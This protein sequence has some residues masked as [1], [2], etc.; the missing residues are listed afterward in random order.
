MFGLIA[1]RTNFYNVVCND[2]RASLWW[3][4]KHCPTLISTEHYLILDNLD[5]N[6]FLLQ[7]EIGAV[8]LSEAILNWSAL[9][10]WWRHRCVS[11][12]WS[13]LLLMTESWVTISVTSTTTSRNNRFLSVICTKNSWRHCLIHYQGLKLSLFDFLISSFESY[14]FDTAGEDESRKTNLHNLEPPNLVK[15]TRLNFEQDHHV[16]LTNSDSDR[17]AKD[18][19]DTTP[20]K[21]DQHSGIRQSS[22]A[23]NG[24]SRSLQYQAHP[25]SFNFQMNVDDFPPL[26]K[27][28]KLQSCGTPQ[29]NELDDRQRREKMDAFLDKSH[30]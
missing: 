26:G 13:T 17:K 22:W 10:S 6:Q 1:K 15:R 4:Q 12:T 28:S 5:E 3:G 7:L 23:S 25:S 18:G 20:V 21:K 2:K 14:N 24:A 29:Q 11:A 9:F 27:N 19:K 30:K 16:G 8:V